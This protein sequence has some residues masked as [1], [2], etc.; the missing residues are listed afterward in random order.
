M[1]TFGMTLNAGIPFKVKSSYKESLNPTCIL[2]EWPQMQV[3][4]LGWD[5]HIKN[6]KPHMRTFG[7]TLNAG[8]AFKVRS[9][10]KESLN[11][12]CVLSEWPKVQVLHLGLGYFKVTLHMHIVFKARSSLKGIQTI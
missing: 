11:P 9:S 12:T 4:H 6:P 7:M 3:L 1:R 5:L 2:L 10:C 8:I